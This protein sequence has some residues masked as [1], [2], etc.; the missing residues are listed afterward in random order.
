[1]SAY[2][3]LSNGYIQLPNI[4]DTKEFVE[5]VNAM[6]I[7]TFNND[8]IKGAFLACLLG[9]FHSCARLPVQSTAN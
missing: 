1:M 5:T 9:L 3:C 8:E 4:D 7:M 2:K 6:R